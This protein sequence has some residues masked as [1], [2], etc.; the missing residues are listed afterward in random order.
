MYTHPISDA[1]DYLDTLG[2][3]A[4]LIDEALRPIE[5]MIDGT[6]EDIDEEFLIV[7]LPAFVSLINTIGYLRGAES[8]LVDARPPGLMEYQKQMLDT[9]IALEAR[10][11]RI[12]EFFTARGMGDRLR[13]QLGE[14]YAGGNVRG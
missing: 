3:L 2:K 6:P 1:Q 7:R 14:Y 9:E 4:F 11:S 8:I 5:I 10:L 12:F 13:N